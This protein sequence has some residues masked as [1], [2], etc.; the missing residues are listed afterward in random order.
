MIKNMT[1][2]LECPVCLIIFK[3]PRILT[4]CGHTF[5]DKCISDIINKKNSEKIICPICNKKSTI[6]SDLK[7]KTFKI[8]FLIQDIL[9]EYEKYDINTNISKSAPSSCLNDFNIDEPAFEELK[10]YDN[11]LGVRKNQ[12]KINIDI[13]S[14]KDNNESDDDESVCCGRYSRSCG[15][16][17][18]Q[19]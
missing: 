15:I 8:N 9:D 10:S 11:S 16:I 3:E 17:T 18:R 12:N 6:N 2:L 14:N 19:I 13:P 1:N 5:C 4:E 7:N